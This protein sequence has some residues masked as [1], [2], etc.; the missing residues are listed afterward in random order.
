MDNEFK[1][2]LAESKARAKAARVVPMASGAKPVP[3]RPDCD[4]DLLEINERYAVVLVA[5]KTRIVYFE[6]GLFAGCRLP[7]FQT[8]SDFRAFHDKRRKSIPTAA[9]GTREIGIGTWWVGHPRRRQ[10]DS[11]GYYPNQS[12]PARLNLWQGFAC[13]PKPGDC[14]LYM[15]HVRH[16]ICAGN[17]DHF[18]YTVNWMAHAVQRP[19]IQ[20]GVAIILRGKEGTGKGVFVTMLGR[21]FGPHFRHVVNEKHLTGNFNAH[22][23]QCTLLYADEA[24]FAGDRGHESTLKALITEDS[25][26]IEPKGLDCFAVRNC[27]HLVMASNADWVVPASADARRFFCLDVGD[28]EMQNTEYFGAIAAQMDTGGREA[29]LWDLLNRDISTFD[30]RRVPQTAA[31]AQQKQYSR[32]GIDQLIE[33][34]AHDGALPNVHEK[35]P[36]VAITTGEER[37]RGF[38][39]AARSLVADLKYRSSP[40]MMRELRDKWSC[41]AW[42]SHSRRGVE[43]PPL[44]ELRQM[45]DRRHGP[46]TWSEPTADWGSSSDDDHSSHDDG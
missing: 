2:K 21:C 42:K 31:L 14:S 29:L 4:P 44:F 22:L 30:V 12:D 8:I 41:A 35:I 38:W 46:Q 33:I 26:L 45:F 6:P 40:V 9:G 10:Y 39:A 16:N 25:I 34:I 20:P 36:H 3:I 24:F 1:R 37:C 32:R 27:V 18:H 23:Q 13:E 15:Q 5:G 11:I 7:V 19:E 28:A 43:F 17:A